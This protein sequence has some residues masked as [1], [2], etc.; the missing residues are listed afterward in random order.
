MRSLIC[1]YK[2][3]EMLSLQFTFTIYWI[4]VAIY[5]KNKIIT[6]AYIVFL[7]HTHSFLLHT[8][9]NRSFLNQFAVYN[10]EQ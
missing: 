7:S 8:S 6:L 10:T 2:I 4:R 9:V 3:Y 1:A 5:V